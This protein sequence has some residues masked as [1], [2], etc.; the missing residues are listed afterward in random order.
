MQSQ[1]ID[2]YI[3]GGT[4]FCDGIENGATQEMGLLSCDD[5]TTLVKVS[6]GNDVGFNDDPADDKPFVG[7]LLAPA[8]LGYVTPAV[9]D[10]RVD[11][12]RRGRLRRR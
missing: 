1:A 7:Q 11:V 8:D 10:R 12:G 2:G 6:G 5:G 3:V 4:V 9:L